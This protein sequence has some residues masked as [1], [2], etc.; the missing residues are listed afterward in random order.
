[1]RIQQKLPKAIPKLK[2]TKHKHE[3]LKENTVKQKTRNHTPNTPT[4]ILKNHTNKQKRV[5]GQLFT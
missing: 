3:K 4:H 5:C 1:M 2:L